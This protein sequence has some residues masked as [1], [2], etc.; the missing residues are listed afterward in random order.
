MDKFSRPV[1]IVIL[2]CLPVIVILY[3]KAAAGSAEAKP[4]VLVEALEVQISADALVVFHANFREPREQVTMSLPSL[5]WVLADPNAVKKIA[6]SKILVWAGETGKV[7]TGEKLKFLVKEETRAEQETT[8]THIGTTLEATP[9]IDKE[10]DILLNFK[11]EHFSIIEPPKEIDPQTSLPIGAPII[12]CSSV[13]S[14][15]KLKSGEP[16]IAGSSVKSGAQ[17]FI[18]VRAEILKE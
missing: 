17:Q 15:L 9:F 16:M 5:L 2:A 6:S 1:C 8:E 11:F 13:N 3:A 14:R 10:G 7:Q 12:D 4:K 18:L